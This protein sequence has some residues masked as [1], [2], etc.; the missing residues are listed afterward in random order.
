MSVT[1]VNF[2][3]EDYIRHL[4]TSSK[5][6][7]NT[8]SHENLAGIHLLF[9]MY[10]DYLQKEK[11]KTL[12]KIRSDRSNLPITPFKQEILNLVKENSVIL[13]AGDTGCGKSTQVP[14]FLNESYKKIAVTQPRRIACMS[15]AQRV[16]CESLC[17]RSSKVGHMIRFEKSAN[18]FT[19]IVFITEGLLL[20][21]MQSDPMLSSYDVIILDEVHERHW[22]TDCLLGLIKCLTFARSEIRVVLMSAT[23]NF[24]LFCSFFDNC[25]VIQVP[26]RL[27][28]IQLKY[29]P[30]TPG[31]EE[32]ERLSPAPYLRLLQH[33]DQNYPAGERGD[34]LVFLA[35]MSDI[36]TVLS[37]LKAYAETSKRWIVLALHSALS[38][39]EQE[40]I[41]HVPPITV[42]K[43][44]LSTNIAETSVTIDGIRFVADSGK[45]KEISWENSTR[46]RR[47]KQCSISQASAEQRKGRAGRTGP[48]VCFRLYNEADF[49][50]WPKFNIPEIRR[51]P[52]DSI[53]LQMVAMGL[54]D[55]TKFPF[56]EIPHE[57]AIEEALQLLIDHNAVQRFSNN[58][59]TITPLGRL[60]ADL[61]VDLSI[62]RML[63]IA[64]MFGVVQKV[65]TLAA[66]FSVQNPFSMK[67][68]SSQSAKSK[69]KMTERLREFESDD[70]SIF[71]V[72][73]IFDEWLNIK[74]RFTA[75]IDM[76]TLSCSSKRPRSSDEEGP[77]NPSLWCQKLGI[78]EQ[79]F[80]EMVRIRSQFTQLLRSCGLITA[81]K[82][83][84]SHD[85]ETR[86]KHKKMINYAK[87]REQAHSGRKRVLT[88]MDD[89]DEESD[90]DEE[91]ETRKKHFGRQKGEQETS[92]LLAKDLELFLCYNINELASSLDE[93][94]RS[95]TKAD[96]LLL[97]VVLAGGLYPHLAAGDAANSYRVSHKGGVQGPGAEM[98]F[99]TP[100]SNFI[101]L[102]PNDTFTKNPDVLFPQEKYEQTDTEEPS[103]S[104]VNSKSSRIPFARDHQLL[105]YFDL[106]ETTKP[107][108]LN[109]IRVPM[110]PILLLFSRKI[111]TNHDASRIIFDNWIEIEVT[112]LLLSQKA[113]ACVI[114]LRIKMELLMKI[115]LNQSGEVASGDSGLETQ[116]HIPAESRPSVDNLV[117]QKKLQKLLMIS[118]ASFLSSSPGGYYRYRKLLAADSKKMYRSVKT[119]KNPDVAVSQEH[120]GYKVNDY[121][122]INSLYMKRSDKDEED[123]DYMRDQEAADLTLR[124]ISKMNQS[125]M[126]GIDSQIENQ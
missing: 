117:A 4:S 5:Q 90:S 100:G 81:P 19:E 75:H 14:Q 71:T 3:L 122:V 52:L 11:I 116:S 63:V 99:H 91:T 95:L 121:L 41:F 45:M 25:P 105:V 83:E 79:R 69:M 120:G 43:C 60:L 46:M 50:Q 32:S 70:G 22:Q 49:L 108:M 96:I 56:I 74:S 37:A 93:Q 17:Q 29:Q 34:L 54:P 107:F 119:K 40:R 8:L 47:L 73:S 92:D 94:R 111:D 44:I 67:I 115:K 77:V 53:V 21:Q 38:I 118:L 76:K 55:I 78:E 84:E 98:V 36:Q 30:L 66:A 113:L 24:D 72:T 80:H 35:G 6:N 15:L 123:E 48:G 97:K 12:E 39:E 112:D 88:L 59:L 102:Q 18:K 126:A 1:T 87:K 124:L 23:I 125:K 64:S 89:A 65:L 27:Y 58:R 10:L 20:R 109:P 16:K 31:E 2:R 114:W 42:R 9:D 103:A 61:P 7:K 68:S 82:M 86:K 26:G 85:E 57:K 106:M 28:P 101:M 51:V 104:N 33:I 13:I 110:L 62:G